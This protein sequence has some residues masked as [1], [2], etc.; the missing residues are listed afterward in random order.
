MELE[1]PSSL[2]AVGASVKGRSSCWSKQNQ[3]NTGTA[4]LSIRSSAPCVSSGGCPTRNAE[5]G[6]GG[7]EE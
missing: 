7:R 3:R 5:A 4:N 2:F 6:K 1:Y